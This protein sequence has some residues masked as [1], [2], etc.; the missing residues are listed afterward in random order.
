[1]QN[2]NK[3]ITYK[4]LYLQKSVKTIPEICA[5]CMNWIGCLTETKKIISKRKIVYDQANA[6]K[7]KTNIKVQIT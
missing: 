7:I 5:K 3:E 6:N 2:N 4:V 1:M